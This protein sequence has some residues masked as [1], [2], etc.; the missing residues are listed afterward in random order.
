MYEEQSFYN[1]YCNLEK[2]LHFRYRA[3]LPAKST[4]IAKI[5]GT[6]HDRWPVALTAISTA[7]QVAAT[8]CASLDANQEAPNTGP[9]YSV[10]AAV[11]GAL[12]LAIPLLA[13]HYYKKNREHQLEPLLKKEAALLKVVNVVQ[14]AQPNQD[15]TRRP[16][17]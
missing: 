9:T 14:N 15:R 7:C 5:V 4:N 13:E 3:P 10:T 2:Q 17:Q 1:R 12:A 6:S 11:T 8:T 16:S